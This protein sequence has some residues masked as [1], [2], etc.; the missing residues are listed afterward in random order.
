MHAEAKD[1]ISLRDQIKKF[2]KSGKKLS[3][4]IKNLKGPGYYSL[5]KDNPDHPADISDKLRKKLTSSEFKPHMMYHPET[6]EGEMANKEEDHIRLDKKGYVHD[7]PTEASMGAPDYNPARG[8]YT[9]NMIGEPDDYY[10]AEERQE[11]YD[12]LQ[13]ALQGNYMDDY[14]KDGACPACGGSGYMDG[15]ETFINDDGEEEESSECDGFGNY[16]CD[17][18]EM[19]YGSDGPS[20]VEIIKHDERKADR[21]KSKDEYPGDEEVIKQVASY[22]K[23]MDDPRMAYQQMQADFPHMGRGQRS[24][25]LGKASKMAFGEAMALPKQENTPEENTVCTILGKALKKDQEEALEYSPQELYSEL[26]SVNPELADTIAKLSKVVYDVR[27]EEKSKGLYYNVN[28]RKKAGTSRKKGHPKAPTKQDWENA[29]KTAKESS[30]EER[31]YKD[32]GVADVQK[33]ARGKEFKFDKDS[34]LFKS[35]DGEEADPKTK[36]GKE[37]MRKRKNFMK[38]S[39]PS[40]NKK[41]APKKKGFIAS[42]FN[43]IEG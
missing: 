9:D 24:E 27:L 1:D 20:W 8:G 36:V 34:K 30:I 3:D 35:P 15:E 18:G 33:D 7:K 14:I 4:F 2:D 40:Y 43:D 31:S 25:I 37:L 16:G 17:E 41:S 26:E 28:K 12:D 42:L 38:R 23:Q 19:T 32:Q 10:D 6:G 39:T 29:A 11:A 5:D 22:M 21:Q 13:D